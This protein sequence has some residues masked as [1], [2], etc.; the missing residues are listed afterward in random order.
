LTA[1]STETTG[2]KWAAPAGGGK[3]LQ[4]VMGTTATRVTS[5]STSFATTNLSASITPSL[6]TSKVLALV[7]LNGSSAVANNYA[8][9]ELRRAGS[10]IV[11]FNNRLNNAAASTNVGTSGI[12]FLDTPATTSATTYE[13]F[14]ASGTSGES[15]AVHNFDG[16]TSSIVLMEIGA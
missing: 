1:D 6:A 11:T 8:V 7:S 9:H 10:G 14:F 3:V 13:V 4:V 2:L 5:T 16:T 15:C 12:A